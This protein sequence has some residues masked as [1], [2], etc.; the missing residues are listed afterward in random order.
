M[1]NQCPCE[2]E[3]DDYGVGESV[4]PQPSRRAW[5]VGRDASL[6]RE[7]GNLKILVHRYTLIFA[8]I[9]YHLSARTCTPMGGPERS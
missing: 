3:R 1:A 6:R 5:R 4:S 2:R 7:R 8:S 9:K